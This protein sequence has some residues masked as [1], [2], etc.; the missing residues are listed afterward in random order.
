MGDRAAFALLATTLPYT[1]WHLVLYRRAAAY[2]LLDL[3]ASGPR[4]ALVHALAAAVGAALAW[5]E[6]A[7]PPWRLPLLLW[8]WGLGA[9]AWLLGSFLSFAASWT[10]TLTVYG[11]SALLGLLAGG[12]VVTLVRAL[13]ALEFRREGLLELF[14]APRLAGGL[15]LGVGYLLAAER[16]GALR[17][18]LALCLAVTL[19]AHRGL[20]LLAPV[21]A[22]SRRL[23]RVVAWSCFGL[24][25]GQLAIEP[26]SPWYEGGKTPDPVVLARNGEAS[27]AI[28][29]SGRGAF[30]LYVDGMLRLS[31]I[32]G[33]RRNEATAHPPMLA[34]ARRGRVLL[35]GG[36]DGGALQELLR[37]PD[38]DTVTLVEPEGILL[39]FIGQP[40]LERE[41][42]G[43]FA[44]SK[45][46]LIRADPLLY[47][48]TAGLFDVIVLD[49]LEP[50]GPRR[51]KWYTRHFY[52]QIRAHL[53]PGGAGA[54]VAGASPFSQRQAYWCVL[55]TIE[56]AGLAAT[57][58]RVDVPT[59]G[60]WGLVLFGHDRP[61]P[62]GPL[63][64][65][66]RYLDARTLQQIF[67]LS[68]DEGPVPVEVNLLHH[69]VLLRYRLP[70]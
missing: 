12:L 47:L 35:I 68:A 31:T 27:R 55:R 70:G 43:A 60:V 24:A 14:E 1:L 34:A 53:A 33:P 22:T 19:V 44:S 7:V 23:R 64:A 32:D 48:E 17:T 10:F 4:V 15:A 28:L 62:R 67:E 8:L 13:G 21:A 20:T 25:A 45:V 11:F 3:A 26:F 54:V 63:P 65:G 58:Y 37:Y 5:R 30:Q 49:L 41:N 66:L 18:G 16:V 9:A 57:P 40:V 39:D 46:R 51:S 69:Q 50:E 52:E 61:A 6:R 36:G 2:L 59:L 29:T 56:A 42:G 38:V